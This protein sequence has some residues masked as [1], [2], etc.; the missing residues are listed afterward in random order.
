[1]SWITWIILG[2]AAGWAASTLTGNRRGAISNIII[3]IIG[4]LTGFVIMG[5]FDKPRSLT[6]SIPTF[7]VAVGGSL[8]LLFLT[9]LI[10]KKQ[11]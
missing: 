1:M 9:S 4:A 11:Y 7:L 3:G 10:S 5:L 2:G 8:V 6:F